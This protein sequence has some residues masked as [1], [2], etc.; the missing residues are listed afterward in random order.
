MQSNINS[1]RPLVSIVI[2][3]FNRGH[4][5]E[6]A[7]QSAVDQD[8]ENL[9]II[10]SDNCS[11]DNTKDIVE[12]FIDDPRIHFF[13]NE[14]NIGM[15]ENFKYSS[16]SLASGEL[17]SFVSSDDFLI[18]SSF[19][20]DAVHAFYNYPNIGIVHSC[21]LSSGSPENTFEQDYSY[22]F[23]KNTFYKAD[24]VLGREVFNSYPKCHSI[25]FGGS[26][27]KRDD[28]MQINPFVDGIFSFDVSL[29]LQLIQK[30]NVCFLDKDTYV[31]RRHGEN[32]T[33]T[34]DNADIYLKNA[35]Y[36]D[37]P[38][39]RAVLNKF[40]DKKKLM[41]WKN[42]MYVTYF[43][44]IS[45]GFFAVSDE[46]YSKCIDFLKKNNP[47][48]YRQLIFSPKFHFYKILKVNKLVS[49]FV[50]FLRSLKT[51]LRV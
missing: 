20:T 27:F 14:V 22:I 5:I 42:K 31:V 35:R 6:K 25:S 45:L 48:V 36:I 19:I 26:V 33:S 43:L 29:S 32:Y 1:S 17:I 18:N 41:I 12:K 24:Y 4:L 7:I 11:Q 46:Q 51:W 28:L 47:D 44:Q 16:F 40:D 37:I 15:I 10:I 3:S 38:F 21:N 34:I 9:E 39:D 13:Q 2:T 8:Y 23:Y 50:N 49:G 30:Y